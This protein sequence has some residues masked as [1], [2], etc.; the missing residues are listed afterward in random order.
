M[1]EELS[2]DESLDSAMRYVEK[3]CKTKIDA[4]M[5]ACIKNEVKS[6]IPELNKVL[7]PLITSALNA[8]QKTLSQNQQEELVKNF[9]AIMMPHMQKIMV[10]SDQ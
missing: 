4:K 10:A 5:K 3:G 8:E 1:N 6:A 9:I 7:T 2:L